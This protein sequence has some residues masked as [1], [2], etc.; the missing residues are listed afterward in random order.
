M[1]YEDTYY[2]IYIGV[3]ERGLTREFDA[4]LEIMKN[5]EEHR[6][7]DTKAIWEYAYDKIKKLKK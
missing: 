4:Q 3:R 1:S 6:Y 2:E 5:Q 7:K